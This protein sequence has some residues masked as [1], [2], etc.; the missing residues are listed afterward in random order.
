MGYVPCRES[1]PLYIVCRSTHRTRSLERRR[2][3]VDS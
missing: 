3:F 2:H 1:D